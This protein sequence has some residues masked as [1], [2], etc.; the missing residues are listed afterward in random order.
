MPL[1]AVQPLA[2]SSVFFALNSFPNLG[3]THRRS[4]DKFA[5]D[6]G[7]AGIHDADPGS[8]TAAK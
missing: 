2:A 4:G 5:P 1:F 3:L 8:G 6:H 7:R